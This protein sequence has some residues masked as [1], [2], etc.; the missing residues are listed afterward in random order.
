MGILNFHVLILNGY[1]DPPVLVNVTLSELI[2]GKI[3][4]VTK[5]ELYQSTDTHC[6]SYITGYFII[7]THINIIIYILK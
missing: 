2:D 4:N 3:M 6:G 1:Y 7:I 5:S